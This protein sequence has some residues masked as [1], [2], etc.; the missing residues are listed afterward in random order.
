MDIKR[1]NTDE[2]D[3]ICDSVKEAYPWDWEEYE[4]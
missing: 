2:I 4:E 3:G 1:A